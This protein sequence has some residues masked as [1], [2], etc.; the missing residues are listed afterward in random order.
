VSAPQPH[1]PRVSV[2][3]PTRDRAPLLRRAL[4]GAL[5]QTLRDLE[6]VVVDDGSTDDTPRVLARAAEDD[7][8][9][10]LLRCGRSGG[11][12]AARNRGVR[13]ARGEWVAF[14]DD[15]DDW[16][17]EKLARQLAVADADPAVGLVYCPYRY[18]YPDG[19]EI[20]L[21]TYDP[22]TPPGPQREIFGNNFLGVPAVLVRR[23]L[24]LDLG[25]FDPELPLLEDWDLW[26]RLSAETTF[27]WVPEPLV[28]VHVT[29]GSLSRRADLYLT[30]ARRLVE[31]LAVLPGVGRRARG[32]VL[33][34][35]AHEL[36]TR[37][38]RLHGLRMAFRAVAAYPQPPGRMA[39]LAAAFV[40][41]LHRWLV[42]RLFDG[43]TRRWERQTRA[44]AVEATR[45]G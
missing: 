27:G 6:V 26:I 41:P 35:L 7:P 22:R 32:Q 4:A 29:P 10:R 31:R 18:R 9:I 43:R 36:V 19:R 1:P 42:W 30:A 44:A 37:G 28:T 12:S 2:I 5:G 20:V 15:D 40:P 25:G 13:E 3:L 21:G 39:M 34:S 8:R 23:T 11:V 45:A 24:L 38:H 33:Y 16:A 14:L 17:P